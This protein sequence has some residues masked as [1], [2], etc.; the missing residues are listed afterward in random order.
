MA[1][2]TRNQVIAFRVT[3]A[4]RRQISAKIKR[5]G[6]SQQEYLLDAA[7]NRPIYVM[8]ELKPILS[9]LRAWGKNLNQLTALAHQG[10]VQTVYL[11]ELTAALG[12]T[13]E[14]VSTLTEKGP[15]IHHGDLIEYGLTTLK[16]YRQDH[17]T[18]GLS[19]GEY[20]AAM[21]GESWKFRL[22]TTVEAVMRIASSRVPWGIRKMTTSRDSR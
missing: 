1:T 10:R 6:L 12:R 20:R 3:P 2:R 19:A 17:R 9:E 8:E 21:R 18:S 15:V 11:Q 4:E 7:L 22:I 5:S 13:Y 14:A 16:P